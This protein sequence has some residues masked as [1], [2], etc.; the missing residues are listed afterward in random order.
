MKKQIFRI[1]I[2]IALVLLILNTDFYKIIH[3]VKEIPKEVFAFILLLQL[4]TILSIALQWKIIFKQLKINISYLDIIKI[5]L[6]GN[7][8]DGVTPGSKVGG[9]LVRVL[10][11]KDC[12][13]MSIS[14]ATLVVGIQKIISIGCFFT[15]SLVSFCYFFYNMYSYNNLILKVIPFILI[16]LF[17]ILSLIIIISFNTDKLIQKIRKTNFNKKDKL[18]EILIILR[19]YIDLIKN[20]KRY[21]IANMILSIFIWSLYAFKLVILVRIFNKNIPTLS[22]FSVTYLSYLVGIIPILPGSIGTFEASMVF[23]LNILGLA[24]EKSIVVA[25]VFRFVTFWFEMIF[26]IG[27]LGVDYL[28][29]KIKGAKYVGT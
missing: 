25:A 14:Q 26:S 12:I 29:R 13:N 6:K 15:L 24:L 16:F 1:L 28:Y 22:I 18:I 4:I 23:L 10:G 19:D 7:I 21:L 8:I 20:D 9:E 11:F 2:V 27:L 3:N 17:L 5:N